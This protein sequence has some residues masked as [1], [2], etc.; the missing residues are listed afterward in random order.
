MYFLF[1]AQRSFVLATDDLDLSC[2]HTNDK[3]LFFPGE[4]TL[5]CVS[6]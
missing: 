1:T 5:C 3:P 4:K 6:K 2:S